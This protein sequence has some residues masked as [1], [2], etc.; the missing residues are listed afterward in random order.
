MERLVFGY[1]TS[2]HNGETP[3]TFRL[4]AEATGVSA[5]AAAG[6]AGAS[7]ASPPLASAP[8]PLVASAFRRKFGARSVLP[9]ERPKPRDCRQVRVAMNET[10][11][12]SRVHGSASSTLKPAD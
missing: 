3:E 5:P 9:P 12:A 2:R 10:V 1:G 6:A 11:W 4:K 8:N 7:A